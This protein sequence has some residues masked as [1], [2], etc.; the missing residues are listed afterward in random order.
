[1]DPASLTIGVLA[2]VSQLYTCYQ[3]YISIKDFSPAFRNLRLALQL[4]RERFK[5]WVECMGIDQTSG[6]NARLRDD[7]GLLDL[8][9][10]ILTK[11]KEAFDDSAKVLEEYQEIDNASEIQD[12]DASTLHSP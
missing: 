3:L 7:A 12:H 4:E 1:M 8:I 9:R 6:I 5:L 2:L 11:L 10:E